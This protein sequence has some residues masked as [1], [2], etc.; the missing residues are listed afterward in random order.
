M[1][2]DVLI[3]G[4]GIVGSSVAWHL[5]QKGVQSIVVI[6]PDLSGEFSSSERNAGGFRDLWLTD[7]NIDL[8]RISIDFYTTIRDKIGLRQKGYLWLYN[9]KDLDLLWE[10]YS[11]YRDKKL[12]LDRLDH[13]QIKHIIPELDKIDD[14]IGAIYSKRSG[15]MNPNLLKNFYRDEA[16][17]RGV[18]FLGRSY[19]VGIEKNVCTIRQH[20]LLFSDDIEALLTKRSIKTSYTEKKIRFDMLVNCAGAWSP[21]VA[22][23]YGWYDHPAHPERRQI[24][25]FDAKDIDMEKYGMVIT[26]KGVYF[27]PEAGKILAG[28]SHLEEKKEYTFQC[29][30]D[31]FFIEY[32]WPSLYEI[33]SHFEYARFITGW[34]GLYSVTPDICGILGRSPAANNIFEVNSFTGRGAMQSY[35]IGLAA[36]ELIVNSRFETIDASPLSPVRFK[37][38]KLLDEGLHL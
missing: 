20:R 24:V 31:S 8:C 36:S 14:K 4:A 1:K 6:D 30:R 37:E 19:A 25:L 38:G 12:P 7:V 28:F 13:D 16:K 22:K 11:L 15:I 26:P 35:G 9:K 29:D 18:I 33:S 10:R 21:E 32:I 34:A 23:L 3:I 2:T 27:H 5:A 17:K